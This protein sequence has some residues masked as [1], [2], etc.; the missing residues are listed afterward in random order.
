MKQLC[1]LDPFIEINDKL[2][3]SD[4]VFIS[5]NWCGGKEQDRR[6]RQRESVRDRPLLEERD[7]VSNKID[8]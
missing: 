5:N 6:D 4:K 7:S 1:G 8:H 3:V 2:E